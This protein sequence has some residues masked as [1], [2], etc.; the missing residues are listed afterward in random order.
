MSDLRLWQQLLIAG[1]LV[2]AMGT[3]NWLAGMCGG[4]TCA[5]GAGILIQIVRVATRPPSR[6]PFD[7][8]V[9]EP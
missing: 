7:D 1:K 9:P 4:I 3:G 8:E 5:I 2:A 6:L